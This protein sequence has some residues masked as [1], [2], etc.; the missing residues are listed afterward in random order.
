MAETNPNPNQQLMTFEQMEHMFNLFKQMHQPNIQI[1]IISPELKIA[2]KLNHQN[3]TSWC[4]MMHIALDYRGRLSHII[5]E[6][7]STTDPTYKIWKQKDSIVLSL[8]RI[9]IRNS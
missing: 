7:P 6:P 2:E 3:Y 4:K 8:S 1:E 5:D 9:L